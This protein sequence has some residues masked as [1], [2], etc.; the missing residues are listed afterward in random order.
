MTL[1]DAKEFLGLF[2]VWVGFILFWL[3]VIGFFVGSII[4]TAWGYD[5]DWKCLVTNC[6]RIK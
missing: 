3:A 6:V 4:L 5:W 2:L 1:E